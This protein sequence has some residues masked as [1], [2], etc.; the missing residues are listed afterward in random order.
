MNSHFREQQRI[1]FC[2]RE[3]EEREEKRIYDDSSFVSSEEETVFCG[4]SQSAPRMRMFSVPQR[5]KNRGVCVVFL[6][7]RRQTFSFFLSF[8]PS[9]VIRVKIGVL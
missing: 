7:R 1:S 2:S 4:G 6:E 8:L 5:S 3:E 9:A